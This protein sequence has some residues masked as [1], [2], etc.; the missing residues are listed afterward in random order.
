MNS[1]IFKFKLPTGVTSLSKWSDGEVYFN[2]AWS[3]NI[4]NIN[5]YVYFR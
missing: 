4:H 2:G 1:Y 5:A 3:N